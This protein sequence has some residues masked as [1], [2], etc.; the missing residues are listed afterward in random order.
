MLKAKQSKTIYI[1]R[2]IRFAILTIPRVPRAYLVE[3]TISNVH[4]RVPIDEIHM[5][6]SV[7]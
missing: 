7:K 1:E 6:T 4:K 2:C 3:S 5:N